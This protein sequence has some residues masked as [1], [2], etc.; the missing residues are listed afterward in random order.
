MEAGARDR[1]PTDS[2]VEVEAARRRTAGDNPLTPGNRG[3][4]RFIE[5]IWLL[6]KRGSNTSE[7]V[8]IKIQRLEAYFTVGA[9]M[10]HTSLNCECTRPEIG[11]RI[12]KWGHA[13]PAG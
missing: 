13:K 3:N 10:G 9:R 1:W 4:V 2:S 12:Q 7:E 6:M 8:F 11:W 5:R